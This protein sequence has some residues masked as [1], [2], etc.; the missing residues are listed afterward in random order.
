GVGKA[1]LGL[2]FSLESAVAAVGTIGFGWLIDRRK[3]TR[4]LAIAVALWG[5][6]MVAAGAATSYVFLLVVEVALGVVIGAAQPAVASLV[7]DL[8]QPERRGQIYGAI[9]SGELIGAAVGIVIS[10]LLAGVSWR[11]GFWVLAL[12]TPLLAWAI[13]RLPEPARGGASF[14]SEGQERIE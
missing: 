3:R 6:G 14:L 9:L 1:K 4:V 11:L 2:L 7:G 10:G 13:H 12:P 5:V 8:F